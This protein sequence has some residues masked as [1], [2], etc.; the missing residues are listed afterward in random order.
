MFDGR[1]LQGIINR[2]LTLRE[3][4]DIVARHGLVERRMT[5]LTPEEMINIFSQSPHKPHSYYLP[6][7]Y[8]NSDTKLPAPIVWFVSHCNDFNGR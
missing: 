7:T 1:Q 2:T 6:E 4:S 5:P 8:N 3:D